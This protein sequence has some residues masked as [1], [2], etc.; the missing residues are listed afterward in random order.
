M[1]PAKNNN[2]EQQ[3]VSKERSTIK[4]ASTCLKSGDMYKRKKVKRKMQQIKYKT[5]GRKQ[6]PTHGTPSQS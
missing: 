5:A 4:E 6:K 1:S 3:P 2:A